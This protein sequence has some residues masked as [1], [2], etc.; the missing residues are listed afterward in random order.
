MNKNKTIIINVI[1]WVLLFSYVTICLVDLNKARNKE[2][3]IFTFKHISKKYNDGNVDSYV[4]LGYKVY[5]YKR[6]CFTG[7][8]YVPI[9]SKDKS[10][11]NENC[12]N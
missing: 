3:P 12:S 9:W 8:E 7:I 10:I 4:G 2:L 5:N 6:K 11:D 1:L